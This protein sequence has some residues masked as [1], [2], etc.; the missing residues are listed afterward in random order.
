MK[1]VSLL[2]PAAFAMLAGC[3][4]TTWSGMV[5]SQFDPQVGKSTYEQIKQ[6]M[7][8]GHGQPVYEMASANRDIIKV[9][10]GPGER[11]VATTTFQPGGLFQQ[12]QYVTESKTI[13]EDGYSYT[14]TFDKKDKILRWYVF[15]KRDNGELNG[16]A[17]SGS[18]AYKPQNVEVYVPYSPDSGGS[19]IKGISGVGPQD[20]AAAPDADST[21][22]RKL[23]KLKRLHDQ[24]EIDD[25]EY[26]RLRTKLIE[27]Y[28][29]SGK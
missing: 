21:L 25:A 14:F 1:L 16:Y 15:E 27:G 4:P 2:A 6:Q 22:D 19:A 17:S 29:E 3:A 23:E 26:K 13:S 10:Y 5:R 24:G 7:A 12:A 8:R 18:E 20:G 9:H 28:T 11:M